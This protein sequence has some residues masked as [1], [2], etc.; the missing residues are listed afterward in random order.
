MVTPLELADQLEE[1]AYWVRSERLGNTLIIAAA[2]MR[3]LHS[4]RE[5]LINALRCIAGTSAQ[6]AGTGDH[7]VHWVDQAKAAITKIVDAS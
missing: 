4:E 2:N 6:A 1:A 7:W 3:L 5:E